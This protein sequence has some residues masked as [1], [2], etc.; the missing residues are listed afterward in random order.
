MPQEYRHTQVGTTMIYIV[1]SVMLIDVVVISILMM[2]IEVEPAWVLPVIL[3]SATG[4]L[5][6][7]LALFC[8]LTVQI[9]DRVLCFW[10][11]P[12][13]IRKKISISEIATANPVRNNWWNGWGIHGF[14]GGV[15]YNIS[16]FDAVEIKLTA[17]KK[18]R[19]GTDE[20]QKLTDAINSA[21][22]A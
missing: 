20:P 15:L 6:I 16:G 14:G 4:G 1:G 8:K 7:C 21:L 10:F 18:L 12:G 11:G 13:L 9:K 5:G 3:A 19:I 22:E 17:G 2:T